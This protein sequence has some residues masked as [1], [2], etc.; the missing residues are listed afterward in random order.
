MPLASRLPY[1]S[2]E[3]QVGKVVQIEQTRLPIAF[4]AEVEPSPLYGL[5]RTGGLAKN[6]PKPEPALMQSLAWG[7][8]IWPAIGT[9]RVFRG[10]IPG[11]V[12]RPL[13]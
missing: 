12:F 13:Y 2:N 1:T 5:N 3:G 6:S 11:W 7:W 8:R 9:G 10:W 4:P